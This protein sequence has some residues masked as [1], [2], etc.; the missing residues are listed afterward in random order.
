MSIL[1][2][3]RQLSPAPRVANA[4]KYV[5]A[6]TDPSKCT[7]CGQRAN[8]W[9][10]VLPISV[11]NL[12]PYFQFPSELLVLVPCCKRCNSIAGN[13]F[14]T[15]FASKINYVRARLDE[16][17]LRAEYEQALSKLEEILRRY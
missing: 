4:S 9:D 6:Q 17:R 13:K 15:S 16:L 11:A 8:S 12:L 1:N 10:H 3:L 5:Y 2:W 14:F 7:Y